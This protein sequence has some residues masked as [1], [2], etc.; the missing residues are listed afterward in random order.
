M[1]PRKK[2]RCER[3]RK[4]NGMVEFFFKCVDG[5]QEEYILINI[6]AKPDRYVEGK[7]YWFSDEPAFPH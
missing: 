1:Y 2:Y 4:N 7:Y 6:V 5:E 3:V